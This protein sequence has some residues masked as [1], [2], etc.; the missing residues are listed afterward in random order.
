LLCWHDERR[1]PDSDPLAG[2]LADRCV[3]ADHAQVRAGSAWSAYCAW[4]TE[5]HIPDSER[6]NLRTFGEAMKGRFRADGGG[7]HKPVTYVG[8]GLVEQTR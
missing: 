4:C 1:G 5:Q 6:L 2:F 8:V 3:V 7:K